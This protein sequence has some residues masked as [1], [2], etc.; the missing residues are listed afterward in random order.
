MFPDNAADPRQFRAALVI[1]A[2]GV[3]YQQ[4]EHA[5]VWVYPDE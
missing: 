4:L 1:R 5:R 3:R 2:P